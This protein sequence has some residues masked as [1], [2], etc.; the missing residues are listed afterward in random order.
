MNK[1]ELTQ[2]VTEILTQDGKTVARSTDT[3]PIF[4]G[5]LQ[6]NITVERPQLWSPENPKLYDFTLTNEAG[7]EVQ[8]YFAV[9]T[10]ETKDING[11]PRLCLNGKPYFFHGLLDQGYFSDGIFTPASP[12]EFK[13]DILSMKE[14]GFNMLRKHIKIEPQ[15]FYYYCDIYGMAVFQ[16]FVNNGRYSFHAGSIIHFVHQFT[17]CHHNGCL[18]AFRLW[19]PI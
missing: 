12:E 7:D 15:L 19:A 10:L 9:R 8:S 13:N 6:Q 5:E 14:L 17:Q 4:N 1:Q 18:S 2:L 3:Q 11:I 16:D